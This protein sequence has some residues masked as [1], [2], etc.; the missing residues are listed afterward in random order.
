MACTPSGSRRVAQLR[1]MHDA[2]YIPAPH[3]RSRQRGQGS[4]SRKAAETGSRRPVIE[5]ICFNKDVLL[6]VK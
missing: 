3:R 2:C 1:A 6:V 4:G 5:P